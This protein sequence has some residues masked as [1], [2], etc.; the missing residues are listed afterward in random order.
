MKKK[1]VTEPTSKRDG[2]FDVEFIAETK[3]EKT[4][5]EGISA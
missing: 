1:L 4:I 5:I 2:F 3:E